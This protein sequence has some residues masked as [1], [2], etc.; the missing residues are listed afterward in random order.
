MSPKQ[1]LVTKITDN[2]CIILTKEGTYKKIPVPPGVVRVGMEVTYNTFAFS[3]LL[4]PI[5]LVASI[6]VMFLAYSLLYQ[7]P[8]PVAVA[9]VSLDINPSLEL[10]VDKHLRVVK[11]KSFNDGGTDLMR[12]HDLAGKDIY[13]ALEILV[14]AAINQKY[15]KPQRDNLVVSTVTEG[16]ETIRIDPAR[17]EQVISTTI[18]A[19]GMAGEVR[20]YT[21]S[22][23]LR[24]MA[25]KKGISTGKF[26]VYNQVI[27]SGADISVEEIKQKSIRQVIQAHKIKLLPNHKSIIM[28]NKPGKPDSPDSPRWL[29][30][31]KDMF[32]LPDTPK[33]PKGS[34]K[35]GEGK[36]NIKPGNKGLKSLEAGSPAVM[37][38]P[39]GNNLLPGKA[40]NKTR[41]VP[42]MVDDGPVHGSDRGNTVDL[43]GQQDIKIQHNRAGMILPQDREGGES[44]PEVGRGNESE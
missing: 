15:I 37:V 42:E 33:K 34:E 22:E 28:R 10:A 41:I 38:E 43:E 7:A 1:G 31:E 36:K 24:T 26:V 20:V 32:I 39:D 5:A 8:T 44:S 40:N 29:F 6:L 30:K 25:R 2:Y 4:K 11:V 13:E 12:Y 9:Y 18:S 35:Q 27:D 3:S 17:V 21:V 23:E 14:Q 16:T 19:R